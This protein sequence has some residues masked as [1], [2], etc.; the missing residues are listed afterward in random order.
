MWQLP[1][2]SRLLK[3]WTD[4]AHKTSLSRLFQ[5]SMQRLAK[6]NARQLTRL[7]C[8]CILKQ[9]P[10]VELS[11]SVKKDSNFSPQY[12]YIRNINI[13]VKMSSMGNTT[14]LL[15]WYVCYE[16]CDVRLARLHNTHTRIIQCRQAHRSDAL[17]FQNRTATTTMTNKIQRCTM[18]PGTE[19]C[20]LCW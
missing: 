3:A 1:I 7:Y 14:R 2:L 20:E 9:C 8:F 19:A 6:L 16:V 10:R 13:Y 12:P 5:A 11:D 18:S 17:E 4:D 15:Q